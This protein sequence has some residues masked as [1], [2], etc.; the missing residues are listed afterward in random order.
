[1]SYKDMHCQI[2]CKTGSLLGLCLLVYLQGAGKSQLELFAVCQLFLG[3]CEAAGTSASLLGLGAVVEAALPE[4]C[5]CGL[6]SYCYNGLL[7]R[8]IFLFRPLHL[9]NKFE[10]NSVRYP[11]DKFTTGKIKKFLQENM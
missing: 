7:F 4:G 5:M 3:E 2:H 9:A 10:A 6:L 8:D 11:E 1:M